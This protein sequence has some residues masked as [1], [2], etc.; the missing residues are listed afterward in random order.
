[1]AFRYPQDAFKQDPAILLARW[2]KKVPTAI[3]GEA[4][5]EF[6]WQAPSADHVL[7][8]LA[9]LADN[10]DVAMTLLEK[11][12]DL[13]GEDCLGG[14]MG[15][16]LVAP[17]NYSR[18]FGGLTP[19]VIA[20]S[21]GSFKTGQAL[22]AC[23][24]VEVAWTSLLEEGES[25]LVAR[26]VDLALHWPS[27]G[28]DDPVPVVEFIRLLVDQ[29]ASLFQANPGGESAFSGLL[30]SMAENGPVLEGALGTTHDPASF[31][32]DVALFEGLL[33]WMAV[34]T[35]E[36]TPLVQS[37]E[38]SSEIGA[39]LE[40]L[41]ENYRYM[42]DEDLDMESFDGFREKTGIHLPTYPECL[43]A[44]LLVSGLNLE[45]VT[46]FAREQLP[47]AMALGEQGRLGHLL[48]EA[49]S[50]NPGLPRLRI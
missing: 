50:E 13:I 48:D 22:L 38:A 29:G 5:A 40:D 20:A 10:A 46:C 25:P 34:G 45:E 9:C 35:P 43:V 15:L 4:R 17:V 18:F 31:R 7:L 36:G 47:G 6:G 16:K 1:M 11:N 42:T 19:L 39:I 49:D 23:P 12:P 28:F 37:E 41:G 21:V 44:W 26:V 14:S 30:K 24:G 33:P 27:T 3:L 32:L 2:L 8:G